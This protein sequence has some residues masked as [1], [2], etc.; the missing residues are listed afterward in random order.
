MTDFG[1]KFDC[2]LYLLLS[3][4]RG[5]GLSNSKPTFSYVMCGAYLLQHRAAVSINSDDLCK[6]LG[7][8]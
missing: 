6:A 8:Q 4:K 1:V 5:Q 7:T 3:C 2:Q